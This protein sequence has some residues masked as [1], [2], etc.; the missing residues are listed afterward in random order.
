MI[1]SSSGWAVGD[2]GTILYWDGTRWSQVASPAGAGNIES[3]SC[4]S[5]TN[6]WA[7]G[8]GPKIYYWDGT[9]WTDRS[10]SLPAGVGDLHSIWIRSDGLGYAVGASAGGFNIIRL[11]VNPPFTI[12]GE[13]NLGGPPAVFRSI[14]L[15]PLGGGPSFGFVV[16]DSGATYSLDLIGAPGTW[17]ARPSGTPNNLLG[18]RMISGTSAYA[19]GALDTRLTWSGGPNW[20]VDGGVVAAGQ[21]WRGISLV[22]S[23]EGWIVATAQPGPISTLAR[24]GATGYTLLSSGVPTT[25]NLNAVYMLSVSDGFAVGD[26]GIIIRW[27]GSAWTALTSPVAAPND[28]RGVWLA[29]TADGWAV[30]DA[31]IILRWNSVGWN[32]YQTSP[33]AT[34]LNEIHGSSSTQIWAVGNDPDGAGAIPP[35]IIRW[36]GGPS[37]TDVSPAGVAN[38]VDLEGVFTISPTLAF[39]VGGGAPGATLLKWDGTIWGSI[40]PGTANKLFSTWFVSS[41]EGW[42]VGAAGTAVHC[43]GAGPV[44]ATETTPPGTPQLNAV[45]ALSSTNVWAVGNDGWIIHRDATGWSRVPSGLGG[46]QHLRS[47]YMVSS[48]EGWAV[49]I[50]IFGVP[51]ILFW[52]GLTWSWVFPIPV[53]VPR[54]LED[55]WMVSSQDGWAVGEDGLILRFGPAPGPTT[56]VSTVSVTATS[57]TTTT[58][59]VTATSTVATSTLSTVTTSTQTV[60]ATT[61]V[62]STVSE[63]TTVTGSTP[64]PPSPGIPGFPMESVLAGLVAGAAALFVLRRSRK[65]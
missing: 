16:G 11:N 45:Q 7:V 35:V 39:A 42:A 4:F 33:V 49:G 64:F 38:N 2:S 65:T 1:S 60:P 48:T 9:S 40:A 34:Q 18:V 61:T 19:V 36:T 27:N 10:V 32:F 54:N 56:T 6:C 5:A 53:F 62:F 13:V 55:V 3:V 17:T 41:T 20:S 43:T 37:W 29:S 21:D 51:I 47:L 12:A 46:G 23:T 15:L 59:Q 22:S 63:T 25:V 28:L 26:G 52:D 57:V 24:R 44:C 30:G 14:H 8:P 31:G 50:N 58:Q